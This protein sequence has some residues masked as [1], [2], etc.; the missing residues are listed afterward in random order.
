M[1][2]KG[3]EEAKYSQN[4]RNRKKYGLML[5]EFLKCYFNKIQNELSY[6]DDCKLEEFMGDL[7]TYAHELLLNSKN[8]ENERDKN[9]EQGNDQVFSNILESGSENIFLDE[10]FEI[11]RQRMVEEL[12]N[13]DVVSFE[14]ENKKSEQTKKSFFSTKE[15]NLEGNSEI[16]RENICEYFPIEIRKKKTK[17][18]NS[19]PQF[20]LEH[21]TIKKEENPNYDELYFRSAPKLRSPELERICNVLKNVSIS[22]ELDEQL[23]TFSGSQKIRRDEFERRNVDLLNF[24]NSISSKGILPNTISLDPSNLIPQ[25][26][27]Y[28]YQDDLLMDFPKEIVNNP[29]PHSR[30]KP[31]ELVERIN[32]NIE[33]VRG[34]ERGNKS[35]QLELYKPQT[36]ISLSEWRVQNLLS[37]Q[38]KEI[39]F[40]QQ[41]VLSNELLIEQANIEPLQSIAVKNF[42]NIRSRKI[43]PPDPYRNWLHFID[44][45]SRPFYYETPEKRKSRKKRK[46]KQSLNEIDKNLNDFIANKIPS[47]HSQE[48]GTSELLNQRPSVIKMKTICGPSFN[49]GRFSKKLFNSEGRTNSNIEISTNRSE[50]QENWFKDKFKI[51]REVFLGSKPQN[52]ANSTKFDKKIFCSDKLTNFSEIFKT[53]NELA[54][55]VL[56]NQ[57]QIIELS[58]TKNLSNNVIEQFLNFPDSKNS[59]DFCLNTSKYFHK[60]NEND[61][62]SHL[63][64]VS[65]ISTGKQAGSKFHEIEPMPNLVADEYSR[66]RTYDFNLSIRNIVRNTK[67]LSLSPLSVEKFYSK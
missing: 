7:K 12:E 51:Y 46:R 22:F 60:L 24:P 17:W 59:S 27:S 15:K 3:Y 42:Y 54:K 2:R 8:K 55:K 36:D 43:K 19:L 20:Q 23:R 65:N 32:A 34:Q 31:N 1:P 26:T 38:E 14:V 67:N 29:L 25:P 44:D 28:N 33:E 64:P 58:N 49:T 30:I 48:I 47:L 45:N 40:Q 4:E 66:E 39:T 21:S 35:L 56:V 50:I 57:N 5:Y 11:P 53:C 16:S 61:Q 41:S 18:R 37:I 6:I 63:N 62:L 9:E 52:Y 13:Q 10:Q